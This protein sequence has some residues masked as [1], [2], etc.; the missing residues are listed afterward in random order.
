M[1]RPLDI[2]PKLVNAKYSVTASPVIR[3]KGV[4]YVVKQ[5]LHDLDS[6]CALVDAQKYNLMIYSIQSVLSLYYDNLRFNVQYAIID[7]QR[8]AS[9][10]KLRIKK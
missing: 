6:L 8:V 5:N 7:P 2:I 10:V 1:K 4:L 9:V 3:Y